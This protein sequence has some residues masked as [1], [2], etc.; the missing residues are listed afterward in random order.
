[1]SH[2][3]YNLTTLDIHCLLWKKQLRHLAGYSLF[4]F[5]T[6]IKQHHFY[7]LSCSTF[8]ANFFN[9]KLNLYKK[10]FKNFFTYT[11]IVSRMVVY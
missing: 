11:V 10:N 6:Y 2:N 1:M 4:Y 7:D 3:V 9:G 8:S 5:S